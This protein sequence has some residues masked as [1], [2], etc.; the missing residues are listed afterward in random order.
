MPGLSHLRG[1]PA[2]GGFQ[3]GA[4]LAQFGDVDLA[5]KLEAKQ[6]DSQIP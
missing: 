1:D 2:T 6:G 5:P 3:D 4:V